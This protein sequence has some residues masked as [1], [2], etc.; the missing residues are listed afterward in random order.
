MDQLPAPPAVS[1]EGEEV[2][3]GAKRCPKH[4]WKRLGEINIAH[5]MIP[6]LSGMKYICTTCGKV[7]RVRRWNIPYFERSA[8]IPP[9]KLE[10]K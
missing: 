6:Q 4:S 2:M 7:R 8:G 1:E 10:E 9:E 5:G 3:A